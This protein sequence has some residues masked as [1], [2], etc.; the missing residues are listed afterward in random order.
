MA[1]PDGAYVWWQVGM[2]MVLLIV[3]VVA[4]YLGRKQNGDVQKGGLFTG[5]DRRRSTSKTISVVWTLF[6]AW[7][8]L[9]IG[10]VAWQ[11]HTDLSTIL[12]NAPTLYLV[13]IGGPYAAAVLAKVS[14]TSGV[15]A[16]RIV[17]TQADTT[18]ARDVIADD[19]GN[20]DLYD[21]QYT[22]FNLIALLMVLFQFWGDPGHGLP[23]V[24]EF[25]AILCGGSALTYTVNKVAVQASPGQASPVQTPAVQTPAVQ[26]PAVQTP[27]VQTPAVQTPAVQ[28]KTGP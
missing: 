3:V 17:K 6:L 25:L 28:T 9:V 4:I 23:P 7:M 19:Q 20:V 10:V 24:P 21:F 11:S 14:T 15:N 16:D 5:K 27:A 8:L 2:A 26:T 12:G 22:L 1:R 18:S 13:L